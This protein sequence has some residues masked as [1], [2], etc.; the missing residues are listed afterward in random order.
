MAGSRSDQDAD[1]NEQGERDTAS[2]KLGNARS[3]NESRQ[4]Q[5]NSS[6]GSVVDELTAETTQKTAREVKNLRSYNRLGLTEMPETDD[7]QQPGGSGEPRDEASSQESSDPG[8][9]D[10]EP[11][12]ARER[13]AAHSGL[14][15]NDR[16]SRRPD[17][18]EYNT[19]GEADNM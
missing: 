1:S 7:T 16:T 11:T 14:R 3:T 9:E 19:P 8:E 13:R 18:L 10:G 15:G 4:P 2:H 17:R 6:D 12:A 5:S